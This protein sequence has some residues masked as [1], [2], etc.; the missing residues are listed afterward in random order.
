V[1]DT[2]YTLRII[3]ISIILPCRTIRRWNW[4]ASST[5]A[6]V[7]IRVWELP[8]LSPQIEKG[9][10]DPNWAMVARN[11]PFCHF[12]LYSLPSAQYDHIIDWWYPHLIAHFVINSLFVNIEVRQGQNNGFEY[13][14]ADFLRLI[15]SI[16][17]FNL[18]KY[19][20]TNEKLM[21]EESSRQTNI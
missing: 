6:Q 3:L 21:C 2:S 19:K 17:R 1:Y 7:S 20:K 10:R 11:L 16:F 9:K 8:Y 14:N 15:W 5:K 12:G 13:L 4:R 18:Q